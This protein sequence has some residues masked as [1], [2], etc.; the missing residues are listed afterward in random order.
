MNLV[1]L[2]DYNYGQMPRI[3]AKQAKDLDLDPKSYHGGPVLVFEAGKEYAVDD[4]LAHRLLR[5]HGP[6]RGRRQVKFEPKDPSEYIRF[7]SGSGQAE[8]VSLGEVLERGYVTPEGGGTE[9]TVDV[10]PVGAA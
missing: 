6:K 10:E 8:K 9:Q 2:Q 1:C 5:D 4:A 3:P 7:L